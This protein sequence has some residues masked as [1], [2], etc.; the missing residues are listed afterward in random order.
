MSW[1]AGD[2]IEVR[3]AAR[4]AARPAVLAVHR[5]NIGL[6]RL[7][8][9]SFVIVSHASLFVYGDFRRDPFGAFGLVDL[10]TTAVGLFFVISGWLIAQSWFGS[11]GAAEYMAKRVLRLYPAFLV[12]WGLSLLAARSISDTLPQSPWTAL[13]LAPPPHLVDGAAS[14]NAMWTIAYELR[15]YLLVALAGASGLLARRRA[16]TWLTAA[17]V[18]LFTFVSL[19]DWEGL[20]QVAPVSPAVEMTIGGPLRWL[21][22]SPW[23]L[24]GLWGFV[25]RRE[26]ERRV[27]GRVALL[28]LLLLAPIFALIAPLSEPALLIL[29]APILYWLAFKARLGPLQRVNGRID[30]S[31]GTYLF[32]WPVQLLLVSAFPGLGWLPQLTIA[33]VL[34]WALGWL[35]WRL[36]ESPAL[37]LKARLRAD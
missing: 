14:N 1:R 23:F 8:L 21:R 33:L 17:S 4:P 24:V 28:A 16:L 25:H 7:T 32:G 19:L 18:I 29:G 13:L 9:A 36:I 26:I 34:A 27:T 37:K 2:E 6:I 31:Y 11:R 10:G 5:N 3:Q 35:S 15:L 20:Y 22:L 30:I 12:A